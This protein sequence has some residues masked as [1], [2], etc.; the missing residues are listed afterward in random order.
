MKPAKFDSV[1]HATDLARP[2]HV[3]ARILRTEDPRLLTGSG[4]YTAD[5][6]ADRI[7]HVTFKRSDRPHARIVGV[8]IERAKANSGVVAVYCAGDLAGHCKPV[9]PYSRMANY[10]ATPILPLATNKVRH[11]GEAV[12]AIV[13]ESRYEAEDALELIDIEYE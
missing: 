2:R 6:S 11:V 1:A 7:L 3:G 12:P 8:D 13:A 10:Y 5:C 4:Q 9:I